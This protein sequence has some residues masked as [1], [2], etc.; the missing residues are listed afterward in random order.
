MNQQSDAFVSFTV[1]GYQA[2][3]NIDGHVVCVRQLSQLLRKR[4]QIVC[5]LVSCCVMSVVLCCGG[6]SV[7]SPVAVVGP[8]E[9][10]KVQ[11][12]V[13]CYFIF[14]LYGSPQLIIH[15]NFRRGH[16]K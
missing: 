16:G 2:S 11:N 10:G 5:R 4:R 6:F 7:A 12:V 9:V 15:L 1:A 3:A 8:T 14:Y 13:I